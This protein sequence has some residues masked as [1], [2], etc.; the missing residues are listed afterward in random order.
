MNRLKNQCR[1][2]KNHLLLIILLILS[3]LTHATEWQEHPEITALFQEANA[4]GTFVLYDLFNDTLVGHDKHRA[5][6]RY[7]PASTFKIPHSL[8]GLASGA[9][10]SVDEVLP[11]KGPEKPFIPAWKKEMGLREAIAL[12]NVPIYQELARRIGP[13]RMREALRQMGYGNEEVG[14]RID[15]F[16]LDGPLAISAVEQVRFLAK[17]AQGS[18]PFSKARQAS[19]REIVLLE[20]T[21][22]HKLYGKTGWQNAPGDGV[23]WWVGWV[24]RGGRLYA[25]ALN[26]EMHGMADAPKRTELGRAALRSLGLL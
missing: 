2:I 5:E 4:T 21:P 13:E 11:Y 8:I 25:F 7:V 23:G 24:E 26:M 16:W 19:V 18:L 6:T 3:T 1:A 15:R 14:E 9:V 20:S 22:R 17:L 12:S 10:A